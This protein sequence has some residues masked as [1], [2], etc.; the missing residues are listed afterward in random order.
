MTI[1][2]I[3][4]DIRGV[5]MLSDVPSAEI[6][7]KWE[8]RLGLQPGE[9]L[10]ALQGKMV[11]ERELGSEMSDLVKVGNFTEEDLWHIAA[12]KYQLSEIELKQLQSDLDSG[13]RVNQELLDYLRLLKPHYKLGVVSNTWTDTRATLIRQHPMNELMDVMLFSS[14]EKVAKPEAA[15]YLRAVNYLDVQPIEAVFIDDTPANVIGAQAAGL[16]GLQFTNTVQLIQSL[17]QLGVSV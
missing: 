1:K 5:L 8:H 12:Q 7:Q 16:L 2:A 14:V 9:L 13:E 17:A 4:L 15:I 3:L 11:A 6:Q 10:G